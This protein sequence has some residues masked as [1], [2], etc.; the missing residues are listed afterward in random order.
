M[1]P[2]RV[3]RAA[4]GMP[5]DCALR[6]MISLI[7]LP[8]EAQ[9][10]DR[11]IEQFAIA[12]SEGNVGLFDPVQII[13]FSLGML[14]VDS[15]RAPPRPAHPR[16][17]SHAAR[18]R[19]AAHT[20]RCTQRTQRTRRDQEGAQDDARTVHAQPTCATAARAS[21]R[22]AQARRGTPR[23]DSPAVR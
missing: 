9:K 4:P 17:P 8:G 10:I 16:A 5:L 12:R 15:A 22:A 20:L 21:P 14:N 2:W 18:V 11:I 7:K 1:A 13:A 23:A 6:R 3:Q 19:C